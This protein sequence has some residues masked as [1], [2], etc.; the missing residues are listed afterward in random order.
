[1]DTEA[2]RTFLTILDCGGFSKAAD[3]LHRSQP[4]ISRRISVLEDE[5]GVRLF[6]RVSGGITLSDAGRLLLPHAQ[7]VVSALSDCEA[8]VAELRAGSAGPV[9]IAAVGTLAGANLT[10]VLKQFSAQH[11]RADL[12][13]RTANSTEISELVR[14]G[15]ATIGLR[16]HHDA[17]PDLVCQKLSAE[18]LQVV[19]WPAHALAGSRI[20]SLRKLGRERWLAFPNAARLPET[21]A[22]NLAARFQVLGITDVDWVPV[23]SLTAQK[24]LVEAGYGLAVLPESAIEEELR[25]GT[26]ATIRIRGVNLTNPVYLVTRRGGYL[27]QLAKAL[28][29]LL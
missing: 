9:S 19:C 7:L 3:R 5:L 27:S 1:L 13:L 15:E 16:Y 17:S 25:A 2:L 11:P 22:H 14:S 20:G 12:T 8:A 28:I 26:L 21:S 29:D 6:E 18:P 24:R 10:P 23:D 4:A